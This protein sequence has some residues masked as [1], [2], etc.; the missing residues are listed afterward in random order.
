MY[1]RIVDSSEGY[2]GLDRAF[3][4]L[5][6]PNTEDWDMYG[7]YQEF[8]YFNDVEDEL[9][10]DKHFEFY[11]YFKEK[12]KNIELIFISQEPLVSDK[13]EYL[14]IDIAG[15]LES[16]FV[17]EYYKY[18]ILNENKLIQSEATAIEFLKAK[19]YNE[20]DIKL[21]MFYIY[22]YSG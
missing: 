20:I 8:L 18:D 13:L 21:E 2:K 15:E 10:I 4:K 22:K 1:I 6:K 7:K 19:P 3:A 17:D 11:N 5:V 9:L 14:G 12:N 16:I